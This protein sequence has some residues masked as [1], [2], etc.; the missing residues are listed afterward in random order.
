MIAPRPPTYHP[1]KGW[2]RSFKRMNAHTQKD[3][4]RVPMNILMILTACS[5]VC[6]LTPKRPSGHTQTCCGVISRPMVL[7]PQKRCEQ[8][9]RPLPAPANAKRESA[10]NGFVARSTAALLM[11]GSCLIASSAKRSRVNNPRSVK[12][13]RLPRCSPGSVE[14]WAS[15]AHSSGKTQ[16]T[17][18]NLPLSPAQQAK[19]RL[20]RAS[21]QDPRPSPSTTGLRVTNSNS[22]RL[23]PRARWS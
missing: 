4:F 9:N 7:N 3:E 17:I 2:F 1:P 6:V 12:L 10:R 18:S 14:Q 22:M 8:A 21:R 13:A 16:A 23:P 11:V 5:K 20:T 15:S 19:G